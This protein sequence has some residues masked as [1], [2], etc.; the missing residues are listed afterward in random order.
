M[1]KT[2]AQKRLLEA[3]TEAA[4]EHG[5]TIIDK[6]IPFTNNDVP[7]FLEKLAE[8]EEQS[9]KRSITITDYCPQT[10]YPS[11]AA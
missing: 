1:P 10:D 4:K 2:T 7:K 8:F 11:K 5:D 3:M 9:R 6:V